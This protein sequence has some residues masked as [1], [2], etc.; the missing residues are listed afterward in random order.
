[1][2]DHRTRICQIAI[3]LLG[4]P[5]SG[6][7]ILITPIGPWATRSIYTYVFYLPTSTTRPSPRYP[8][9]ATVSLATPPLVS[10]LG[11]PEVECAE[12]RVSPLRP[13]IWGRNT[14]TC[15]AASL[16]KPQAHAGLVTSKA[17]C[18]KSASPIFGKDRALRLV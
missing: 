3:E 8:F 15:C 10:C 16:S 7:C 1:M 5:G 13:G 18:K 4:M 12:F 17:L 2:V 14:V 6:K 9:P 11:P